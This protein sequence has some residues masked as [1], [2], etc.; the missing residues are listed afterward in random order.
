MR[1]RFTDV[2]FDFFGTLV[3]YEPSV[4][5][6]DGT[7][8]T[9]PQSFAARHGSGADA[10]AAWGRAWA[11]HESDAVCT[12]REY[13]LSQVAAR[14]ADLI[15]VDASASDRQLLVDEYLADWIVPVRVRDGAAEAL[16]TLAKD[17]R[18][19]VVSNTH[20]E[21]LV[22]DLLARFD[23][24]RH[25]EATVL[26]VSE[27]W[28]KPHPNLFAAALTKHPVDP[29]RVAFI[30]DTWDADVEGPRRAGM[31]AFFV[32]APTPSRPALSLH[33]LPAHLCA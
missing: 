7:A 18:V 11:E 4:H 29:S 3:E 17:H 16:A 2:W 5:T 19:I 33:D 13:S 15:D 6:G 14:F 12:G 25:I 22:P 20:D 9:A 21:R 30:G 24:D 8:L 1:G 27:G 10:S 26:S 28:R 32:G 23:L 31:S